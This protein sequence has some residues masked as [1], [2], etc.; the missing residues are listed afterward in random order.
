MFRDALIICRKELK[1]I[2]KDARTVFAVL[3][4]PMLIM[5]VIFLVM[6][7]VSSSQSRTYENTVYKLNIINL[8]DARFLSLL[9][10]MISFDE[11]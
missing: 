4:L 10:Q 9:D 1:N 6:N 2:F 3:I 8:P 5:P 7:T 11:L